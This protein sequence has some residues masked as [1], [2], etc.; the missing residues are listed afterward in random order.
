M[1]PTRKYKWSTKFLLFKWSVKSLLFEWSI[2]FL[3]L[4]IFFKTK[5]HKQSKME[6]FWLNNHISIIDFYQDLLIKL[7]E[8]FKLLLN[9]LPL[10]C[11]LKIYCNTLLFLIGRLS[12]SWCWYPKSLILLYLV[13]RL[14]YYFICGSH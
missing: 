6:S 1:F 9:L 5:K 8:S 7:V 3:L 10:H 11:H 13:G 14:F 2:K 12:K 4:V